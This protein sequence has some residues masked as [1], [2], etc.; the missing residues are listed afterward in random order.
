[1]KIGIIREGKVPID[2]RTPLTPNQCVELMETYPNLTI[3]VQS[4][5]I[6]TILDEEYKASNIVV[7]EDLSDCD[8]IFGIKQIPIGE[9]LPNKKYFFFSHTIKKQPEN[10][11]LLKTLSNLNSTLIDYECIKNNK[12]IRTIAFGFYAGIV[13]AYNTIK[14]YGHRYKLFNLKP[15]HLCFDYNEMRG[16]FYDLEPKLK[17]IK[18]VL[19]GGG[20]VAEGAMQVLNQMNIKKVSVDSFLNQDYDYPVYTQLR[21]ENYNSK[22]NSE[23]FDNQEFYES[24]EKY[25]STFLPFA[26]K[27]NILLACAFWNPKAP[28]LFTKEQMLDSKFK[29][30]VIGDV[31]CDINGSIPSTL[32]S[33]SIDNP[34]YDYNPF[35]QDLEVPYSSEQNITT[36]AI[37][38]LPCELSR[39]ASLDFGNQLI[40]NVFPVLMNKSTDLCIENATILK[41]G[42]LTPSFMYLNDYLMA[43]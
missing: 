23:T 18:I 32:R 27:A 39:D 40:S 34:V 19:T 22:E 28:K 42:I 20:R 31:T 17:Q 14:T 29:I 9:L 33:S 12:N 43:K 25:N 30:K 8:Y 7:V 38:N 5:K 35:T 16:Y 21:S 37:D 3:V 15:A 11:K 36:M 4:S 10:Q 2:K 13:G 24:P 6:R 41:D 26:Y 1:M